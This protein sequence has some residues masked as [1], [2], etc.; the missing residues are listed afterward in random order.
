MTALHSLADDDCRDCDDA[1]TSDIPCSSDALMKVH[2]PQHSCLEGFA[3]TTIK[4]QHIWLRQ[5]HD[6]QVTGAAIRL[7]LCMK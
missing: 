3:T 5:R 1:G 2:L 6:Q 7:L 4:T